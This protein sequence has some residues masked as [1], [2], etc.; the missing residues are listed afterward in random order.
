MCKGMNVKVQY[1]AK[2]ILHLSNR[3]PTLWANPIGLQFTDEKVPLTR[4]IV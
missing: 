2:L 1:Y 4:I 3:K